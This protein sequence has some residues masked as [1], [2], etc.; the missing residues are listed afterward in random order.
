MKRF[1]GYAIPYFVWLIFFVVVPILVMV[2]LTFLKMNAMDFANASFSID[3]YQRLADPSI[4]KALW[5]SLVVAVSTVVVCLLL[6]YP[7]AYFL[8]FSHLKNKKLVLL[9][10]IL[11]MWSN[12]I[13]RIVSWLLL[14]S[15]DAFAA[16]NVLGSTWAVVFVTVTT[17]LPFMIFPIFTILEKLDRSLLEASRDLG[18]PAW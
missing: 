9:L 1:K 13:L 15:V 14:F 2:V 6:G 12:S 11:P 4:L 3:S 5:N 17:Y 7:T 16:M 18:V 10:M 8:S